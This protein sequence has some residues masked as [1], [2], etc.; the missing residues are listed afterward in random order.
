MSGLLPSA[1]VLGPALG[2][3]IWWAVTRPSPPTRREERGSAAYALAIAWAAQAVHF[4]EEAATAFPE[5]LGSVLGLP[6]MPV[7]FFL[8][9]NLCWLGIWGASV[10][11]IRD[12]RPWAFLAA[13]FLSIAGMMNGVL[14]PLLAVVT[15]EYFP[16]LWSSPVVGAASAW[17]L[18][19]LR[20][21]TEPSH[22]VAGVAP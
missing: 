13:W 19:K 1:L 2:L 12:G 4:A 15:G 18:L 21:A 7:A 9:F 3:A 20:R 6:T 8:V 22:P 11:P 17:L 10:L 5:R 14:H 16:G